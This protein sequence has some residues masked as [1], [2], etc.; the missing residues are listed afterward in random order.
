VHLQS[1]VGAVPVDLTAAGVS[2][3]NPVLSPDG[4]RIAFVVTAS[5]RRDLYL[6]N[7][8]GSGAAPILEG[9]DLISPTWSP[10]GLRLAY[11]TQVCRGGT[12]A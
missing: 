6:M 12:S 10:D 11:S 9:E 2:A 1:P 7:A 8:D 4:L 3:A 5:H